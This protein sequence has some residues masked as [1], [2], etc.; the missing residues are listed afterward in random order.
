MEM[1]IAAIV[2]LIIGA[3]AMFAVKRLNEQNT[4]KTAHTEAQRILSKAQSESSKL[5][6]DSE[7]K[8]KDFEVKARKNT[9][10]EINK[11]KAQMKN[12]ESQ[13]E[14][15]LKEVEDQHKNRMDENDKF[16]QSLK[17]RQEKIQISEGSV[18]IIDVRK[19]SE[20]ASEH[21]SG[22]ENIPLE[23][24]NEQMSGIDKEQTYY[25]HCAGGYRSMIFNSLMRA[26][27]F[28]NLIDIKG[29]FKS[30]KE[31]SYPGLTE[32]VCPSTIV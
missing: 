15:R 21:I 5:K 10:T 6:K 32:Y 16:S 18:K 27:G 7:A 4:K 31:A 20:F 14:R 17:D 13:L 26:R 28:H 22:S 24:I 11:Q 29:G 1:V 3:F 25:I 2:G 12:K 23:N 19:P 9:E 8:A 30:I